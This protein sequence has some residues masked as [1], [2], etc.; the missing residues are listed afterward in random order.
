M[1][2][3]QPLVAPLPSTL[4]LTGQTA[5]VTGASAGLGLEICRQLLR[6]QI[7]TLVMA[8]RNV[9]KGEEIKAKLLADNY[10][11]HKTSATIEV[12]KLDTSSYS[13]VAQFTAEFL[14]RHA[15]LDILMLNA[16]IGTFKREVTIDGH[17]SALQVNYLS[18]VALF[19]DLLSLL[20][21]TATKS[22]KPS[23]VSITGSRAYNT[24][25]ITKADFVTSQSIL[26]YLDSPE[27]FN[28]VQQ[29][30]NSKLLVAL[31]V[32]EV[33]ERYASDKV[34]I[35]NFCPGM[36]DTGMSDVLPVY[37]RVVA[38]AVK[39][40]RARSAETGASIALHAACVATEETHG[41][42]LADKAIYSGDTYIQSARGDE[43]R[44]ILWTETM[45][46]VAKHTAL[47]TWA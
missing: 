20:E 29:Y 34:I 47:P 4:D 13:S 36:L 24:S 6:R 21:A 12:I 46:E 35:N 40:L 16:G 27:S 9:T 28:L 5:L 38:N 2:F 33:A 1:P 45:E 32:R 44:R 10:R 22:G 15:R 17:E 41:K 26:G 14:A 23:R 3:R 30:A 31:F 37:L 7:A 42:F 18:N 43:L 39:A 19:F 11:H 25:G 8:V